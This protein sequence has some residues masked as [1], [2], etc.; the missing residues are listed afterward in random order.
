MKKEVT[1]LVDEKDMN[2]IEDV[3][4]CKV[5]NKDYCEIRKRLLI[6]WKQLCNQLD[7]EEKK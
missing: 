1:I 6:I 4:F 3:F 7:K 2:A 5:D